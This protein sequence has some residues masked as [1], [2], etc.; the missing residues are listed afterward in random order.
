MAE[1]EVFGDFLSDLIETLHLQAREI[2]RITTQ[3]EQQTGPLHPPSEM[4]LVVSALSELHSRVK[5]FRQR[6]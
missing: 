5:R 4:P 2:E 3:L 1:T 6:P